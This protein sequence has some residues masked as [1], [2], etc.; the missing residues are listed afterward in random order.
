MMRMLAAAVATLVMM[1]ASNA[2]AGEEMAEEYVEPQ[3]Y[4]SMHGAENPCSHYAA[5][6]QSRVSG[7]LAHLDENAEVAVRA[8]LYSYGYQNARSESVAAHRGATAAAIAA[9]MAEEAP[10]P[11]PADLAKIG[12]SAF[13]EAAAAHK[14]EAMKAMEAM[15]G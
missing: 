7:W 1:V 15:E 10:A 11:A 12:I 9:A 2:W 5:A 14:E 3:L 4:S 13:L 6:C 8:D